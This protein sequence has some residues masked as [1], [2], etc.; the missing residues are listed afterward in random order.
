MPFYDFQCPNCMVTVSRLLKV[1]NR[2]DPQYH[3]CYTGEKGTGL[4]TRM[5]LQLSA[6]KTTFSF[7]DK[8]GMKR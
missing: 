7:A 6:P 1:G 3:E 8:S 4:W 2:D 5:E